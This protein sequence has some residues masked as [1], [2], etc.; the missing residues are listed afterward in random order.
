MAWYY[1]TFV[2]GCEGRV[3][4][5]GP[6]KN[7]EWKREKAFS[8]ECE[9]CYKEKLERAIEKD[10][11]RALELAKEMELPELKGTKKQVAWANAIR[12]KLIEKVSVFL[13]K[14]EWGNFNDEEKQRIED[15]NNISIILDYIIDKEIS[16]EFWIDNRYNIERGSLEFLF[17]DY[18]NEALQTDEEAKEEI[19]KRDIELES[20]VSP[21]E[22]IK[23]GVVEINLVENNSKINLVYQKDN[24]FIECVKSFG[25]RW[26]GNWSRNITE[27]TGSY[28]DRAAEIANALLNEGFSVR[29]YDPEIRQK[30]ISGKFKR[31]KERWILFNVV[32]NKFRI[33][34]EYGNKNLYNIIRKIPSSK[35][36]N[37]QILIDVS[38]YEIV[39][40]FAELYNFEFT[41]KANEKITSYIE[42]MKNVT[43]VNPEKV[44]NIEVEEKGLESIL[45]SSREIIDDLLDD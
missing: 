18:L 15:I 35:Y 44:R 24:D 20:T 2:C 22:V 1:G 12:Q 40:E 41:K 13:E 16:S 37:G 21:K 25:Y 3:N 11:K 30:A 38:N 27:I 14:G 8:K 23:T 4:I 33:K 7:R 6:S 36:K 5:I 9:K 29:I 19:I 43:T 28:I 17:K 45:N 32:E 10:N 31:E 34:W 39:R 42:K 26:N